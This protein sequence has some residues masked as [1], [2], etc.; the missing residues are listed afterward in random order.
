MASPKRERK[1]ANR[2]AKRA[3]EERRRRRER[4]FGIVKRYV[5]YALTIGAVL[6]LATV[7]FGR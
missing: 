2:A 1:R 5:V 7:V 3:E 4:A 6:V